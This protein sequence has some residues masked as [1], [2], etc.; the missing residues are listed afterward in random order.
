MLPFEPGSDSLDHGR[1]QQLRQTPCLLGDQLIA[2]HDR[3]PH[4]FGRKGLGAPQPVTMSRSRARVA[5]T[6]RSDR[7]RSSW[8]ALATGSSSTP[9]TRHRHVLG[10]D[11]GEDHH[12]E[13]QPLD[14]VHRAQPH[15][16]P[17]LPLIEQRGFDPQLA[18]HR[19][20]VVL[21]QLV[22][23]GHEAD[24]LGGTLPDEIPD[25]LADELQLFLP[26]AEVMDLG[27]SGRS[28]GTCS[29]S[30]PPCRHRGRRISTPDSII[31]AHDRISSVV[32]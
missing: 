3:P 25:S 24:V 31:I 16:A 4:E 28:A 12:G 22:R 17:V 19:L 6:N 21:E 32:R 8:S 23:A 27:H 20:V 29:L 30:P 18:E 26:A 10:V 2:T 7:S 13:L 15:P 14:P 5:A 9:G 11:P 1:G